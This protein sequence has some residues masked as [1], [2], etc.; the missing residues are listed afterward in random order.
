MRTLEFTRDQFAADRRGVLSRGDD[1]LRPVVLAAL[2]HWGQGSWWNP[3]TAAVL[4]LGADVAMDEGANDRPLALQLVTD[5][6]KDTVD[7]ALRH[8]HAPAN[9]PSDTQ[10]EQ[11]TRWLSTAAT[12]AGT[13]T[14]ASLD[15]QDLDLEWVT[16][17]DSK[18]RTTHREADGQTVPVGAT[19]DIGGFH[20][21]HPGE[22]VG[23]PDIWINCRCVVRP[24]LG[25]AMGAK[26]TT[27]DFAGKNPL[28]GLPPLDDPAQAPVDDTEPDET[29]PEAPVPTD[30]ELDMDVPLYGVLAPEGVPTGDKRGFDPGS[31]RY[32][33]LPLPMR[34][35]K[36]DQPGH[37]GSVVVAR[38][39]N[40][41]LEDGL[42]KF[43]GMA[44]RTPEAEE[45]LGLIAE[46]ML[47]GVSVDLDDVTQV[48]MRNADGTP[49]QGFDE[50][51]SAV[52]NQEE[53][54]SWVTDGRIASACVV[55]IPAFQEAFVAIGTWADANAEPH[56]P[57]A[58]G[59]EPDGDEPE[60]GEPEPEAHSSF[61]I[62]EAP[63]DGNAARFNDAQW[64]A[65][66]ILDRGEQF[67]TAKTRYALPIKE[68][69][70]DLSRAGVHAAAARLDQVDAPDAA[71]AAAKSALAA[72]YQQLGEEAP[73]A[74]AAAATFAPGTHDGPGWI[75]HPR[76]TERI[77]RYWV[78]GKGAAKIKWGLPHDFYRCRTQL[79]K[80]V[81]NPAWLDGL[82]ANMH[83]EALGV[84][85]GGEDLHRGQRHHA[86]DGD[87][88]PAFNLVDC[89][90]CMESMV[91]S[92]ANLPPASW[93]VDPELS[94]PTGIVVEDSGRI[95]GHLATWGTCHIG[96]PG[97]CVTPPRSH[98]NYAYF[99]TGVVHT[100]D[101]DIP[102]GHITL[103]TGHADLSLSAT[104]TLAHY[105]QTGM[106][107]A[108]VVAGEDDF[109]IWIA[110]AARPHLDEDDMLALRS[111]PLSG[112]W[113]TIGGHLE[114]V[115]ALGV[116]VPGFPVPR[117]ALAASGAEQRALVAAGLVPR[118]AKKEQVMAVKV[119]VVPEVDI[120]DFTKSVEV[121][122]NK[123]GIKSQRSEKLSLARARIVSER[124]TQARNRL[125]D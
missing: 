97:Q 56:D 6:L 66:C 40:I 11:I 17:H 103:D 24:T 36:V 108:D 83:K 22:P 20:L 121:A 90:D 120:E 35:Q 54:V 115:A 77:R 16:M 29:D 59:S 125:E 43:E 74:I 95:Y 30:D 1:R 62:S 41:W 69:N 64:K 9:P 46:G 106:V 91:A 110:G 26:D 78:H 7:A 63:W 68:P 19:F 5:A 76:A 99:R 73:E 50:N 67:T 79:R 86:I 75:T 28:E 111:A 107:A 113:R 32:R 72:A 55:S 53:P 61:A 2:S 25:D 109:G 49:W 3:I 94:G 45:V 122:L 31:L 70:G 10:V 21:H 100:D 33:D 48:E 92:G 51:G 13:S 85:P 101:G 87:A 117:V 23:P 4:D 57:P 65:S 27:E 18:V 39:D 93:F 80:Y 15:P 14:A 71:K 98:S 82:C 60:Q 104:S 114:M 37:D 38:I 112:D 88:A 47:R 105:D 123:L 89:T 12:N 102:V 118:E 124:L 52:D 44:A 34:W 96:L 119:R 116:N 42:H 8:T 58:I 84:W 81:Q